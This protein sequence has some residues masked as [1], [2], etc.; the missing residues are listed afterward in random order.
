MAMTWRDE[1][2]WEQAQRDADYERAEEQR[3]AREAQEALECQASE[4]EDA[5]WLVSQFGSGA[6]AKAVAYQVKPGLVAD[7]L[8][9]WLRGQLAAKFIA[10]PDCT[11]E[12]YDTMI[13]S[14]PCLDRKST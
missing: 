14:L 10:G 4:R 5:T 7:A 3:D 2:Y 9:G 12:C 6:I 13:H 11:R 8:A 1:R